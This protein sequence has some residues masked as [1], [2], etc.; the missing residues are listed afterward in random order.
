MMHGCQSSSNGANGT[1]GAAGTFCGV[2]I[3]SCTN[4]VI[5]FVSTERNATGGS[6]QQN[7]LSILN[8]SLTTTGMQIRL[9]HGA[10]GGAT[11]GTAIK[12]G[13]ALTGGNSIQ[14]N[15]MGGAANPAY[16]A[17]FTP[18]PY[19]A[20]YHVVGALTGNIT[21]AAPSNA[22]FGCLLTINMTASGATRTVT[23]NA[24]YVNTPGTSIASGAY[25]TGRFV[26]N[27]TSWIG[28]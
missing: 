19:T 14:V 26:Y 10:T 21:I 2:K 24:A 22:H 9:S 16:A 27:G 25:L 12:S 3:D 13:S 5:D 1:G 8:T 4:G 11:V 20:T 18:D 23:W 15:G 28:I 17:T 7:A 6:W